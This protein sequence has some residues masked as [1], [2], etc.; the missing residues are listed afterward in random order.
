[1]I[2]PVLLES[3]VWTDYRLAVLFSVLM[4]LVLLTWAFIR[5]SEALHLLLTIYWKV[6]S[7]L[8]ITVYLMI[9]GFG[10]GFITALM[11]RIL[12]PMTLWFWD[13]LNEEIREQPQSILRFVFVSWRWAVTIYHGLGAIALLLFIPCAFSTELFGSSRC[14]AW[15]QPNFLYKAQFHDGDPNG[16]LGFFGILG[17]V[18][19]MIALGY[20]VIVRLGRQGRSAM[21]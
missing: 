10:I 3:L 8:M 1:M 21:N 14:Q 4:P 15:I 18:I 9:G 20:F 12:I 17:L 16:F 2:D 6:A 11:A 5:K 7:L 13:D 19:Y